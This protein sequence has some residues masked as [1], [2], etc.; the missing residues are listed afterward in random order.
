MEHPRE[1]EIKEYLKRYENNGAQTSNEY[2]VAYQGD[3]VVNEDTDNT[4]SIKELIIN[5]PPAENKL[6]FNGIAWEI[7]FQ[8]RYINHPFKYDG[9]R[10]IAYIIDSKGKPIEIKD[11]VVAKNYKPTEIDDPNKYEEDFKNHGIHPIGESSDYTYEELLRYDEMLTELSEDPSK[12]MELKEEIIS[13]KKQGIIPKKNE[14]GTFCCY[15][16]LKNA[17][18]CKKEKNAQNLIRSNIKNAIKAISKVYE[19]KELAKHLDLYLGYNNKSKGHV[20]S[21]GLDWDISY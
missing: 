7:T 12:E 21:G 2:P 6:F 4:K 15:L 9:M 8:G 19:C 1:Q 16:K 3:Q 14:N 20:Y 5:K 18:T 10:A 17:E 11:L 13:L